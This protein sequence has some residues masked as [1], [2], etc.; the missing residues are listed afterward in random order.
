MQLDRNEL[1]SLEGTLA[2][3]LERSLDEFLMAE[4]RCVGHRGC[5]GNSF[6]CQTIE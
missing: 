5:R 4:I 1:M 6:D 2:K 3:L